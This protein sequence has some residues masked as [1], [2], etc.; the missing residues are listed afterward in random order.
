[1]EYHLDVVNGKYATRLRIQNKASH[2]FKKT[3]N[4]AF[5]HDTLNMMGR[6]G[7]VL[8]TLVMRSIF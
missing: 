4:A 8:I 7:R 1:M 3:V 2:S 6:S 5:S